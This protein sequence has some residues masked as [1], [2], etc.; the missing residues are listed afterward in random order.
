MDRVTIVVGGIGAE[1]HPPRLAA[2]Q[3]RSAHQTPGPR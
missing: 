3:I 2:D 1:Q